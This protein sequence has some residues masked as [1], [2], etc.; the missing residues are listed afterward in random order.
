[1]R[2][3]CLTTLVGCLA[4]LAATA[5]PAAA[6]QL[7]GGEARRNA[8]KGLTGV[9]VTV[10]SPGEDAQ[11]DGVTQA[12]I[13]KD[14]EV[15]LRSGGVRVLS[16]VEQ[17]ELPNAPAL[18]VRM[19]TVKGGDGVGTR[20]F[21]AVVVSVQLFQSARL[22]EASFRSPLRVITWEGK[23]AIGIRSV[24][25]LASLGDLIKE[26]IDEFIVDWRA[27]HQGR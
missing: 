1:M 24:E 5:G 17:R 3:V 15:Q 21:Y 8:L 6:Q 19:M 14:V 12:Q 25:E 2:R 7:P 13:Q 16:L 4:A 27:A 9:T 11:K 22:E 23:V 10:T 26:R 18:R 20:Y